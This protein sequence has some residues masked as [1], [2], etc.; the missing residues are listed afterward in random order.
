MVSEPY[1]FVLILHCVHFWMGDCDRG[2][3]GGGV[4]VLGVR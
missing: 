1:I 4:C 2:G 3:G